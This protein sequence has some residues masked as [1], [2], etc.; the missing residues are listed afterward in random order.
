M[1]GKAS[2]SSPVLSSGRAAT[3]ISREGW[4]QTVDD[5]TPPTGIRQDRAAEVCLHVIGRCFRTTREQADLFLRR[6]ETSTFRDRHELAPLLHS[7]GVELLFVTARTPMSMHDIRDN[8][9]HPERRNPSGPDT[10]VR[11]ATLTPQL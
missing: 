1:Q 4:G 2:S 6:V 3:W 7:E 5:V 8:S 11:P 9:L 10:G